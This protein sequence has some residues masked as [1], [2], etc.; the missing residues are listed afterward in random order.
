MTVSELGVGTERFALILAVSEGED[1]EDPDFQSKVKAAEA[2]GA[3][4]VMVTWLGCQ[5]EY[6]K[7]MDGSER[8]W[9]ATVSHKTLPAQDA[10]LQKHRIQPL[11]GVLDTVEPCG[12]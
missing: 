5:P 4:P 3:G 11:A 8:R 12:D 2:A 9:V 1:A 6:V 10:W 7:I